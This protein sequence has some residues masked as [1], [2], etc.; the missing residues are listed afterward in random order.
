ML[1]I[2]PIIE[3]ALSVSLRPG[4]TRNPNCSVINDETF[5]LSVKDTF[6]IGLKLSCIALRHSRQI[7]TTKLVKMT[8]LLLDYDLNFKF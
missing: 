8:N 3:N 6:E 4:G 5:V 2:A 1:K 7:N